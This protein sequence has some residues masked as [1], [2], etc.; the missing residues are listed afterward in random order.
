MWR[1]AV[2]LPRTVTKG[3]QY[4]LLMMKCEK[5]NGLPLNPVVGTEENNDI[6]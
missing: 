4:R 5:G 1:R 2:E 6:F 3:T